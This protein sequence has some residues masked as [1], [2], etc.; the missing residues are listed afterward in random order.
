MMKVLSMMMVMMKVK[1]TMMT[2]MVAFN[3]SI[4]IIL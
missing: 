1:I 4:I 3:N 2:M